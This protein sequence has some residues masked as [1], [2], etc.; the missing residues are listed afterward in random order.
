[1]GRKK[2]LNWVGSEEENTQSGFIGKD[3]KIV[4]I[5]SPEEKER[6]AEKVERCFGPTARTVARPNCWHVRKKMMTQ[7][8]LDGA[9]CQYVEVCDDFPLLELFY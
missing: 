8:Q 9:P 6:I 5:E 7:G 4:K 3:D 1:M 2:S